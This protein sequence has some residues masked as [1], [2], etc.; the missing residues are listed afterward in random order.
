MK[1]IAFPL[2]GVLVAAGA[3]IA[4]A[5][6]A[7]ADVYTSVA[8]PTSNDIQTGLINTFPTG[9]FTANNALATPFDI[10]ASGNNFYDG[11]GLSGAG[12]FDHHER[13]DPGRDQRLYPDECL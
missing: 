10:P 8:I 1:R 11:F 5:Q 4:G 2:A 7:K 6:A 12:E 9:T 3:L 13:V